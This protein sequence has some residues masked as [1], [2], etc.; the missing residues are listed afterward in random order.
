MPLVLEPASAAD[1]SVTLPGVTVVLMEKRAAPFVLTVRARV[2]FDGI[3][4]FRLKIFPET[5]ASGEGTPGRGPGGSFLLGGFRVE[6]DTP[7]SSNLAF[8]RP[9]YCSREVQAG[10]PSRNLTDGFHATWSQPAA[11]PA[12]PEGFF[13]MD[14][15]QLTPLDH[16]VVRRRPAPD[17]GTPPGAYHVELLTESGGFEGSVIWRADRPADRAR[18]AAD[19]IR[20]AD[21]QGE[22]TGR[23]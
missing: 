3:T 14:L 1:S 16:L 5:S 11:N 18:R 23:L 19:I 2:P 12:Q 6:S 17:G 22:F 15:G 20:A 13:Q 10:L 8:E 4:G 9:V 21:G 7:R